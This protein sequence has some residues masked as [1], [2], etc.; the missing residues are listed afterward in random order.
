L[1]RPGAP[2][3]AELAEQ[4]RAAEKEVSSGTL[5]NTLQTMKKRGT[6]KSGGGKW[7]LPKM[8]V[9]GVS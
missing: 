9:R 4:L 3:L 6:V 7:M 5:S 1:N 2:P 8:S